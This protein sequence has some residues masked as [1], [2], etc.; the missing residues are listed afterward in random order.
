MRVLSTVKEFMFP[1]S[2]ARSFASIAY[3]SAYTRFHYL[4]AYT[5]ALLN[6]QPIG[7]YS[8]DT[9]LNDA[10]RHELKGLPIDIQNSDWF[11]ALEELKEADGN[12]IH[13]TVRR[14]GRIQICTRIGAGD[15]KCD[16]RSRE[17]DGPFAS[18]YD[19]Q[20]RVPSIRRAE[21]TL[22]AKI[23]AFNWTGEK[24]SPPHRA[25]ACGTRRAECR[26]TFRKHSR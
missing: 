15:R 11:C 25:L 24:T 16:C 26:A 5:C 22:L 7:F 10:K 18:E 23:G 1:D 14:K 2:H 4:A 3:S 8:P 9:I 13:R 17:V 19:L 12:K 21:L 6:N 20:R